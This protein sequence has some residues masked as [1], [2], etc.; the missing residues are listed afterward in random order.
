M[1]R[2]KISHLPLPLGNAS[3]SKGGSGELQA[4]QSDL[5]AREGYGADHLEGDHTAC[6]GQPGESGSTSM[7]P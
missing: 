1:K 3:S 4:C 5:G 6:A 7:G 2:W